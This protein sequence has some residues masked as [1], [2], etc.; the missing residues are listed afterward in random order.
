M[1]VLFSS[2]VIMHNTVKWADGENKKYI[3]GSDGEEY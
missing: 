3:Q 2:V 1:I